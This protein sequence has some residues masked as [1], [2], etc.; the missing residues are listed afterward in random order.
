[1][2]VDNCHMCKTLIDKNEDTF[3]LLGFEEDGKIIPAVLCE[4]CMAELH[5]CPQCGIP[6][7][8]CGEC[9]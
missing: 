3:Y 7:P 5:K 1:M 4:E 6:R 2:K 9:V 8:Y